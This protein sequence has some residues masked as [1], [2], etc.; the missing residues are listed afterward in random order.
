MMTQSIFK[1]IAQYFINIWGG[2]RSLTRA[3]S[4]SLPYLFNMNPNNLRKEVT[5]QYPD[6][7]S[8][9]TVDDLPPRTRGLIKNDIQIC[10]GCHQCARA[11]PTNCI[12]VESEKD[13][14]SRKEWVSVYDVDHSSCIFCGLCVEVCPPG[15]L[16]HTK[17]YEGATVFRA[18]LVESFGK[19]E[20][21]NHGGFQ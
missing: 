5:E 20:M 10:I 17:R 4:A 19:G 9:R 12:Q 3:L 2:F 18:E 6:P 14:E 15:S 13:P 8:S 11:C 21:P 16:T 7:V 1:T